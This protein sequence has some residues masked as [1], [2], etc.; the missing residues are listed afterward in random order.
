M[1]QRGHRKS[2]LAAV[3]DDARPFGTARHGRER[4]FSMPLPYSSLL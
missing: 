2:P 3:A 1:P 4:R